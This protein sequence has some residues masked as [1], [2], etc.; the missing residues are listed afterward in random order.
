M[1]TYEEYVQMLTVALE[2]QSSSRGLCFRKSFAN[3]QISLDAVCL[4]GEKIS[5]VLY[6]QSYYEQFC[7]GTAVEDIAK[8][9]LQLLYTAPTNHIEG[10]TKR[11]LSYEENVNRIFPAVI[12]YSQNEEFL[13]SVPHRKYL[14]LA[15]IY[16]VVIEDT[17]GNCYSMTVKDGFLKH[18]NTTEEELFDK[19]MKNAREQN[20]Y[21]T[22]TYLEVLSGAIEP[23]D[24]WEELKA[25]LGNEE[26]LMLISRDKMRFYGASVL[27]FPDVFGRAIEEHGLKSTKLLI[28]PSSIWEVIIVPYPADV[29]RVKGFWEI[30][31]FA[32][33][34]HLAPEEVLSDTEIYLYEKETNTVRI[35]E[36]SEVMDEDIHQ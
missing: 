15:V 36:K 30:V 28:M 22:H 5:P 13:K 25:Q 18:W 23:D 11:L 10:E 20:E 34:T 21:T 31:K 29:E 16:K 3:N 32:N 35:L 7:S 9:M 2:E 17:V 26:N 14:D 8:Q 19:A 33:K 4:K 6:M 12:N 27:L 1:K 24:E